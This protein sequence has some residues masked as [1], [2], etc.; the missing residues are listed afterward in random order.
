MATCQILFGWTFDEIKRKTGVKANSAG[1][2]IKCAI[3]E[4]GC[5]DF[6]KMLAC[7][8]TIDR[9]GQP[10]K[11][12]DGTKLLGNICKAMLVY[13]NLQAHVAILD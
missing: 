3:E 11:V 8:S 9:P 1:K 7:I 4:A 13:N 10:T 6:H 2:L 12:I 5:N